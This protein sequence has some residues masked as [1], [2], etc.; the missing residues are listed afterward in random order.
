MKIYFHRWS[1][2]NLEHVLVV[3]V[4]IITVAAVTVQVLLIKDPLKQT[5][6][7]VTSLEP[8][9]PGVKGLEPVLQR[10]V[11]TFQ[12]K[13]FSLLPLAKVLVNGEPG[14]E[15]Q[16]RYVTV[17]VKEGDIL[18]V[19]GTRYSRPIDIEVLDASREVI[20]PAAGARFRV[21]GNVVTVGQ[22]RLLKKL[23]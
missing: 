7:P 18:E 8:V 20:R 21:D 15:F 19:D 9:R 2:E 5:S 22:V 6:V 3:L 17:F 23:E 4:A 1:G 16:D 11:V 10:P 12:L 13:N 14:G